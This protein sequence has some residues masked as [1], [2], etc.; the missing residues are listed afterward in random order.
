MHAMVLTNGEVMATW[1]VGLT[2]KTTN[3]TKIKAKT[4]EDVSVPFQDGEEGSAGQMGNGLENWCLGCGVCCLSRRS[5]ICFK[6]FWLALLKG[7]S[8]CHRCIYRSVSVLTQKA[9]ERCVIC[10]M[11]WLLSDLMP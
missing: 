4:G 7:C 6:R 2:G 11:A 10:P 8:S 1:C 9:N 3:T 5:F